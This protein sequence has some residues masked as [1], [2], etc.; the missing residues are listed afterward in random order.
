[1]KTAT[2]ALAVLLLSTTTAFA[3]KIEKKTITSDKKER[4]YYLFVPDSITKQHPAPLIVMLHGSGRTGNVLLEHWKSLAEKE[5]IILAGPEATDI[6]Q[7]APPIDGPGLLR[8]IVEELKAKYPIDERRVYLFGHSAGARFA[9]QLGLIQSEYFAAVAVH[10]GDI[11]PRDDEIM[12]FAERKIP[13]AL[14]VGTVDPFFPLAAVRG[15][16]DMLKEGEF[17]VELTEIPYHNHDYYKIS[18]SINDIVWKFLKD[19]SLDAPQKY[20]VYANM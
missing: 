9:L 5:G 10:A 1:M 2:L 17:P 12:K 18:K 13:F 15:T 4:T 20:K 8:D 3:A 7:W 11:D 6:Q 14:I 19:K 16:R